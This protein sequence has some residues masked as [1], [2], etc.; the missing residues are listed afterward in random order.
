MQNE[1]KWLLDQ[2]YGSAVTSDPYYQFFLDAGELIPWWYPPLLG[3]V[4][5]L[6]LLGRW[7]AHF[8]YRRQSAMAAARVRTRAQRLGY[9]RSAGR[10]RRYT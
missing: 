3:G 4:A 5:L 8:T 7:Y 2:I 10:F 1:I 9:S 6:A